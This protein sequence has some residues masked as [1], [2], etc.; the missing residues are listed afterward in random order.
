MLSKANKSSLSLFILIVLYSV[1]VIGIGKNLFPGIIFLTP[2]NL[3][4]SLLLVLWNH[5]VWSKETVYFLL[6][7]FV[8]G[9][10]I[11]IVGVQS[12]LIFG[13]YAYG[14]VL[15]P[16]IAGTPLMIG[17]NWALLAYCTG[18]SINHMLNDWHW[19]GQALA[20]ALLMVCLDFFIEPVAIRYD[21]WNW[22]GAPIPMQNYLAWFVISFGLLSVF[23]YHQSWITN[24]VGYYLLTIQFLFFWLLGLF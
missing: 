24:K 8:A 17:V 5:S 6:L 12:G 7:C 1:G 15:G 18:V 19:L 11:E 20:G 14:P 13:E 21:M 16:K 9:L 4:I 10:G 22:N 3:L 23:H 2:L